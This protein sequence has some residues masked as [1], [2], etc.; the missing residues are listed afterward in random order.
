[1]RIFLTLSRLIYPVLPTMILALLLSC[2]SAASAISLMASAAYLITAAALHPMIHELSLAIVGV[3]FFG[4]SRAI[5]RYGE[6]YVSHNATFRILTKL[7]VFCYKK[8]EALPPSKL[9]RWKSGERSSLLTHQID[10]LK[11][12]YL[13]VLAPPLTAFLTL[14]VLSV[15]LYFYQPLTAFTLIAAFL[16][17]GLILP[18]VVYRLN[19]KN[20][21]AV[22]DHRRRFKNQC[23]DLIGGA[24]DLTA[25]NA[26]ETKLAAIEAEQCSQ[27][28]RQTKLLR[29]QA[30]TEA[31]AGLTANLTLLLILALLI[32]LVNVRQITGIQLAVLALAVQSSFETA[33][34]LPPVWR[35]WSDS[36]HAAQKIHHMIESESPQFGCIKKAAAAPLDPLPLTVRGL[37]FSYEMD[38]PVLADLSFVLRSGERVAIV[39]A[40]G[41][42]KSTLLNLLLG[43]WTYD[44]GDIC[45]NGHTYAELSADNIR[46]KFSVVT[47]QTHIF[48]LSVKEN[49]RMTH[50]NATDDELWDALAQAALRDFFAALPE[51]LDAKIGQNGN[52]LSGGQRQ[53]L[54]LARAF[55][56]PAPILLLDEPTAGLDT[57]T[58]AKIMQTIEHSLHGRAMLLI[59]HQLIGLRDMDRILVLHEGRITEQGTFQALL[60]RK[61]IFHHMWTLWRNL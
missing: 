50:P 28:L 34:V 23:V 15:I 32:P 4:I 22:A 19:D 27:R 42:G 46:E 16:T 13:R 25:C 36:R 37:H 24:A 31:F 2:L 7:R 52:Q 33:L 21:E 44:S 56:R 3:R 60:A 1:M 18:Y 43:L 9:D 14:F 49:L 57:I 35:Y 53:R 51:G 8:M 58:A 45:L 61:G 59:T 40:S 29:I 55:L 41:A 38:R 39:G 12:F 17:I 5:F 54:A 30:L 47:Q 6:R 10:V 11:D 48:H 20:A 26:L